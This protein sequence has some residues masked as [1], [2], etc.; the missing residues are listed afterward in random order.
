MLMFYLLFSL[1]NLRSIKTYN[2]DS[3]DVISTDIINKII[4]VKLQIN[5]SDFDDEG[6]LK[7]SIKYSQYLGS[8]NLIVAFIATSCF[9][10]PYYEPR[11]KKKGYIRVHGWDGANLWL[12]AADNINKASVTLE[13]I[14]I[15]K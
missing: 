15:A 12:L 2:I 3:L 7:I 6:Y 14:L 9:D 5:G 4:K 13:L 10:H 8:A 1:D 11:M